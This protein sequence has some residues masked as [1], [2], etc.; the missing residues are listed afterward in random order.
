MRAALMAQ[1][2]PCTSIVI[3][4]RQ[5][6]RALCAGVNDTADWDRLASELRVH[7]WQDPDHKVV[8]EALRAIKS[9]DAKTRREELPAQV[10]RMGFPDVDWNLY[11]GG[12]ELSVP[13]IEE[14]ITQLETHVAEK[15]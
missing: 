1:N 10:T 6:L 11:F 9:H 4:E 14:L 12:E 13:E 7:H 8:Y 2:N 3:L 5:I 15:S